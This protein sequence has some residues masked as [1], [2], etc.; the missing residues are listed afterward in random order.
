MCLT[1]NSDE[2]YLDVMC[3]FSVN[4]DEKYLDVLCV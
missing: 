3:V 2:K 4:S 1:V